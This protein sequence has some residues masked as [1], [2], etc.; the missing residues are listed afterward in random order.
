MSQERFRFRLIKLHIVE[1]HIEKD[2]VIKQF[3]TEENVNQVINSLEVSLKVEPDEENIYVKAGFSFKVRD[4]SPPFV[5]ISVE[6]VFN[7]INLKKYIIKD[8]KTG[9]Y[10]IKN[11]AFLFFLV[12]NSISHLRAVQAIKFNG[13]IENI[14]FVPFAQASKILREKNEIQDSN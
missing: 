5:K 8:D 7:V 10:E 2:I 6:N 9:D 12:D 1:D 13:I 11:R 14:P 4:D 3:S